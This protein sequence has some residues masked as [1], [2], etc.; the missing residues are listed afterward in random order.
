[1]D[2]CLAKDPA[3]FEHFTHDAS[4]LPM[5]FLPM[6]QRQFRRM[7]DKV[8]RS[9]WYGKH[10]AEDHL[11]HIRRRITEEGPLSTH[12]F[13]TKIQGAREM[14][15]RPP[16]KIGLDYLWYAGE[17]A[18]YH[19]DGF[20]K[21]YD[22]AERVFPRRLTHPRHTGSRPDRLVVSMRRWIGS[23]SG[24]W[25]RSAS[26]GMRQRCPRWRTGLTAMLQHWFP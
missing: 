26:S 11:D 25:A 3:V 13:D 16:H 22:L 5:A 24:L 6:W 7:R 8:S 21:Y 12:D 20:T 9:S 17:L 23:G 19:R 15:K 14:W 4:V 18:T 2:R 1:M 10:L